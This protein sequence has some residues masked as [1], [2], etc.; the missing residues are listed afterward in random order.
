MAENARRT[1][2]S[3]ELIRLGGGLAVESS[4]RRF[5][6]GRI[7]TPPPCRP[8]FFGV[9]LGR[10]SDFARGDGGKEVFSTLELEKGSEIS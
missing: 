6:E 9:L 10:S 3:S 4:N 2:L 7:A 1:L 5:L 8:L